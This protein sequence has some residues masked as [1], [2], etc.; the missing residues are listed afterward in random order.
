MNTIISSRDFQSL[1]HKVFSLS[2]FKLN[3]P[4]CV[5]TRTVPLFLSRRILLRILEKIKTLFTL[6]PF[7]LMILEEQ[8]IILSENKNATC[9]LFSHEMFPFLMNFGISSMGIFSD[10]FPVSSVNADWSNVLTCAQK[11]ALFSSIVFKENP[12]LEIELQS[13]KTLNTSVRS[14]VEGIRIKSYF[15]KKKK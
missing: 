10:P 2:D 9:C 13:T 11:T 7:F 14:E 4:F 8:R 3:A 12:F 6:K 1:N 15:G 5:S